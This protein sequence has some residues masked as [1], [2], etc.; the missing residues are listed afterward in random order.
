MLATIG[1]FGADGWLDYWKSLK[2]NDIQVVND[3]ETAYNG[4]FSPHGGSRP[5]VVSYASSPPAEVIFAATP[6]SEAPTAAVTGNGSCFR[7]IEFAGILKGGQNR[8]LAEKWVDFM[9]STRF[10]EDM[11]LQMFVFPVS[12]TP[13]FL[14]RIR[15]SYNDPERDRPGQPGGYRC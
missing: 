12:P 13:K 7:Q 2:A 6:V 1:H 14:Q 10:Q 9:L 8:D 5:V 11:P 3:W 4:E 15:A